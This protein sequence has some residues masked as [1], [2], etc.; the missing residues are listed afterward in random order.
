M[1]QR[2]DVELVR[3]LT[4]AGLGRANAALEEARALNA[5]GHSGPAF[6]WAI[7]AAEILMRDFVLTPH[8]LLQGLPWEKAW[9]KGSQILG[10]SNWD[11]AFAKADEWY[12]PFDA[13]LTT[14]ERNA[15]KVWTSEAVRVRGQVVHGHAVHPP[16]NDLTERAIA[17]VERMA[18]WYAQRFLT[19]NRHPVG[20]EFLQVVHEAQAVLAAEKAEVEDEFSVDDSLSHPTDVE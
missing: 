3:R 8:Y 13:P 7:R 20:Q 10:S 9:R 19:S 6:V 15:W 4:Q 1:A 16:A 17:F 14:D 2:I 12:G 11:R 5:Q 18:T